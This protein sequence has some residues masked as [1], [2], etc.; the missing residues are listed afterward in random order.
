MHFSIAEHEK[1]WQTDSSALDEIAVLFSRA[2]RFILHNQPEAGH[3]MSLGHTA[4]D[5]HSQSSHSFRSVWAPG[6]REGAGH[7]RRPDQGPGDGHLNL[8]L[9]AHT[10]TSA[11]CF[12]HE[13]VH[14]IDSTPICSETGIRNHAG[15]RPVTCRS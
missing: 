2:P 10:D 1:V 11:G 6:L 5:Y 9:T 3:N 15:D 12:P 14:G 8:K 13:A 7:Q 4:A